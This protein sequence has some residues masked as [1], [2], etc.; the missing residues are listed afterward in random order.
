MYDYNFFTVQRI[1]KTNTCY[2]YQVETTFGGSGKSKKRMALIKEKTLKLRFLQ[3][4]GYIS[5]AKAKPWGKYTK[6]VPV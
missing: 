1:Y 3:R 5:S 2:S 4:E 6:D